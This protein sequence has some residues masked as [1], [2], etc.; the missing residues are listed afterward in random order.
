[1]RMIAFLMGFTAMVTACDS[2]SGVEE[3]KRQAE[4]ADK[5]RGGAAQPAKK[6]S[7][8]VAEGVKIP[9]E[10]LIDPAVYTT[11]LTEAQPLTVKDAQPDARAAAACSLIRGGKRP[12][13]AEQLAIKKEKGRV[14]V[15]PGDEVCNINI[16]CWG[17]EDADR[18]KKS[19][20]E[21]K[22]HGQKVADDESMGT[23]ACVQTVAVGED[24]VHVFRFF[25]EDTKCLIQVRGGPSMT[26]NDLIL[27]CARTA[28]DSITPKQIAVKP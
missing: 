5:A 24:D 2:K 7:T 21:K 17:L 3:A 4:E 19:C 1:M 23:Y 10:Q 27:N 14:G 20:A 22:A 26:D 13:E 18:F 6:V 25:D 11:A 12:T 15:I 28:R 9:C 8:P 16:F